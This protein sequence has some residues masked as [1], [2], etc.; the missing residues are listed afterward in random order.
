M[1][2]KAMAATT[3]RKPAAKA[4]NNK[5]VT[6]TRRKRTL[7]QT[8]VRI[9]AVPDESILTTYIH[10]AVAPDVTEFMLFDYAFDNWF[11]VLLEGPAGSGKTTA[12]EAWAA[13]RGKYFYA[14]PVTDI[15]RNGGVL[16]INEMNL[17]PT[18]VSTVLFQLLDYRR[19]ITLL[20]HGGEVIRAHKG[21]ADCWCDDSE[22]DRGIIIF[23]DMNPGYA[24]TVQLNDAFRDRWAVQL[25]WD[26][27]ARV[28]RKLVPSAALL[29]MAGKLRDATASGTLET[30]VSTR[31]LIEFVKHFEYMGLEFAI[32]NFTTRF[33]IDDRAVVSQALTAAREEIDRDLSSIIERLTPYGEPFV[34]T[35]GTGR[36]KKTEVYGVD[37]SY[38][39][40][41]ELY[42][43]ED[44][45]SGSADAGF[46]FG[47]D[48]TDGE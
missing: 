25:E 1:K 36:S 20:D 17:I 46:S 43:P 10:R 18:K 48:E 24:G 22:C 16:L 37:W 27:D 19:A 34:R 32:K 6:T 8:L 7:P 13:S 26:Y 39:E 2:G 29:E 21:G 12:A 38:N 35:V 40:A 23:G 5:A 3:T 31:A 28:E 47:D 4:A 11:N 9:S 44:D 30:P 41:D 42:D 15:V 33:K 14:T 45:D